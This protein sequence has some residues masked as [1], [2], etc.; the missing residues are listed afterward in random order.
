MTYKKKSDA[1]NTPDDWQALSCT[2]KLDPTGYNVSGG[3]PLW[4]LRTI[5]GRILKGG[6]AQRGAMKMGLPSPWKPDRG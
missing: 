4:F 6:P 5:I 1:S 3:D 2:M